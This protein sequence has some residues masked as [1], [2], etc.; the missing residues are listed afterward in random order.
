MRKFYFVV[1]ALTAAGIIL[2]YLFFPNESDTALMYLESNRNIEAINRYKAYMR[3][4]GDTSPNVIVP[5]SRV[6]LKLGR[7]N[8]AI[9]LLRKYVKEN[10]DSVEAKRILGQYF[11]SSQR[12]ADF[13]LTLE[14]IATLEPTE[15][16]YRELIDLYLNKGNSD[17]VSKILNQ[18]I[19][20]NE[21]KAKE[22]D[23]RTL[24]Y[25]YAVRYEYDRVV[26]FIDKLLK[27]T[28]GH[29]KEFPT[30]DLIV[31]SLINAGYND[32]AFKLSQSFINSNSKVA[33]KIKIALIFRYNDPEKAITLLDTLNIINPDNSKILLALLNIRLDNNETIQVYDFL[34]KLYKEGNTSEGIIDLFIVMALENND[35]KYVDEVLDKIPAETFS[36]DVLMKM[37]QTFFKEKKIK[38][39]QKLLV[40]LG[41]NFIED[42][43]LMNLLLN[44]AIRGDSFTDTVKQALSS[45]YHLTDDQ[46]L[47]FADLLFIDGSK[48]ESFKILESLQLLKVLS[49]FETD[50]FVEMII[51]QGYVNDYLNRFK[52]LFYSRDKDD[53]FQIAQAYVMLAAGAGK[54]KLY[55]KIISD[56]QGNDN[57]ELFVRS[58]YFAAVANNQKKIALDAALNL[59]KIDAKEH[60]N[61]LCLVEA[62]LLNNQYGNAIELLNNVELKGK[63][64]EILFL[65]ILS[66][67]AN[68]KGREFILKYSSKYNLI[69]NSILR[70][71]T[72]TISERRA[73]A[74]FLVD[75]G[76]KKRAVK[77]FYSLAQNAEYNSPD[78]EQLIYLSSKKPSSDVIKWIKK[79]ESGSIG[80]E[81][82]FWLSVFNNIG[83]SELVVELLNKMKKENEFS[84]SL[85]SYIY[86]N[87][88]LGRT[89]N[90]KDSNMKNI[91]NYIDIYLT[92]LYKANS[93]ESY[94]E[95]IGNYSILD[96]K[97]L[98]EFQRVK[99]TPTFFDAGYYFKSYELFKTLSKEKIVEKLDPVLVAN[100]Y[101]KNDKLNQGFDF[102]DNNYTDSYKINERYKFAKALLFAAN[103]NGK[104]VF[105]WIN[106]LNKLDDIKIK[107]VYYT[108]ND[109]KNFKL[110][111]EIA[112][113]LYNTK[114][115][116]MNKRLLL[117]SLIEN[118]MFAKALNYL[119]G[120]SNNEFELQ[121]FLLALDGLIKTSNSV[122][123]RNNYSDIINGYYQLMTNNKFK[124]INQQRQLG[125]LLSDLGMKEKAKNIFFKLAYNEPVE[126]PDIEQFIFLLDGYADKEVLEWLKRRTQNSSGKELLKWCRFL[127]KTNHPETVIEVMERKGL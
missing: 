89:E 25:Y 107:E 21:I 48:A 114:H 110:A 83:K 22:S 122:T 119:D 29:I 30:M 32:R 90:S 2:G 116:N 120:T 59:N 38:L 12:P 105:K 99:L 56:F 9:S 71:S 126:S 80:V 19:Q 20:K 67:L 44:G 124:D 125:Y 123:I 55:Q 49:G 11:S 81:K 18:I 72:S 70:S 111:L 78:V 42:Y 52:R 96:Y 109:Y 7:T 69:I 24:I 118:K 82:R 31:Y 10:P 92:A 57:Y 40:N 3:I 15:K 106:S 23:Y 33:D 94:V 6:Y 50:N 103:D 68:E 108:A 74:Y 53:I 60:I 43:P 64:N 54:V 88:R 101:L 115:S 93:F 65:T 100:I 26:Y 46:K 39:A 4:S 27:D 112:E 102:F 113:L 79:R 75:I 58:A 73:V 85:L 77:L 35:Y 17:S 97:R 37:S 51:N 76:D 62:Y 84:N 87:N 61:K 14:E 117:E 121:I 47:L 36:D 34:K 95:N 28:D 63:K 41:E 13:L 86:K 98:P 91:N 45:K 66:R 127:N 8:E 104:Q 5:L 1:T 16:V